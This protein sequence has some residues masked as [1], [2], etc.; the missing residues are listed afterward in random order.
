MKR[1]LLVIA[2]VLAAMGAR[3]PIA[4]QICA[5]H[6]NRFFQTRARHPRSPGDN[7]L[8]STWLPWHGRGRRKRIM[9]C[10]RSLTRDGP[11]RYCPLERFPKRLSLGFSHRSESDSSF[12]LEEASMDG[13][14]VFGGLANARGRDD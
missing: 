5:M 4:R 9:H 7:S 13:E 2:G 6:A 10:A 12:L 14:A 8:I 3:A 1:R 11:A